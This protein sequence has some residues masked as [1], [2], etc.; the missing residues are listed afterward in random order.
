MKL[1]L[2]FLLLT[3]LSAL[4]GCMSSPTM[5]AS[6][7]EAYLQQFIGLSSDQIR[8]QLDLSRIGYQQAGAPVLSG[9]TLTYSAARAVSIPA[10][11]AQNPAMGL[12]AGSAVPIPSTAADRYDVNLSCQIRFQLKQ[13]IAQAVYL[14]GRTC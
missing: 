11:M 12:G 5:N 14:T 2:S 6:Q 8:S 9:N 3:V 1:Q 7:R 13:N 10:P 4:Y